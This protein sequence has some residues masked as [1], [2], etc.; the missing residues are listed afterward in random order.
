MTQVDMG[1]Y[2]PG[3]T[4]QA[5]L[6]ESLV[7]EEQRTQLKG[8]AGVGRRGSFLPC[9]FAYFRHSVFHMERAFAVFHTAFLVEPSTPLAGS[10][11][12]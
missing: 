10:P 8:C 7:A 1:K 11:A 5:F 9:S 3:Q 2:S 4:Q 6:A 12:D